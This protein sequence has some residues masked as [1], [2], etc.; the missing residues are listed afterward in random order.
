MSLEFFRSDFLD[1]RSAL[2]PALY[3]TLAFFIVY[4]LV[5]LGPKYGFQSEIFLVDNLGGVCVGIGFV[6]AL[7]LSKKWH[8]DWILTLPSYGTLIATILFLV[9][10]NFYKEVDHLWISPLIIGGI[11]ASFFGTIKTNL[12]IYATYL[13]VPPLIAT[14]FEHLSSYDIIHKQAIIYFLSLVSLYFTHY[15]FKRK[16]KLFKSEQKATQSNLAKSTFLA[17]MSHE[18]RTPMN[19]ILGF[20]KLLLDSKLDAEQ[21]ENV[22]I[23]HSSTQSLLTIIN[24]IL[25]FSKI[26]FGKVDLEQIPFSYEK[27]LYD[28]QSLTNPTAIEK[29]LD[30][31]II[32]PPN[33]P[34]ELIGDSTRVRQI[35]LNLISNS[36]KFTDE[37]SITI[38]VDVEFIDSESLFITTSVI[39]TGIGMTQKQ[40]E[41]IFAEFQQADSSTTRMYGGTGLGTSISK[42]IIQLM[43]GEITVQSQPG[44]GST[45]KFVIPFEASHNEEVQEKPQISFEKN[46]QKTILLAEDNLINQKLALKVFSSLGLETDIANNGKEAIELAFNNDYSIIL[47][48][49]QMPTMDG[50]E[51]IAKLKEANYAKP[52]LAMT[53]NIMPEEV[54]RYQRAGFSDFI[55]K[56]I[57]IEQLVDK[58]DK[59]LSD[60]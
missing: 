46:Y 12:V 45:F 14:Q 3:F 10:E 25:D 53:A 19:G 41:N 29:G 1:R 20:S 44:K 27:I 28:V 17:N 6:L 40:M 31:Q 4:Y 56:P 11:Y 59:Y 54:K 35:L 49:I 52:I 24:D 5:L 50:L 48:D 58:F 47:L 7:L 32:I 2:L 57:E 15:N 51:A 21:K 13:L 30:F 16:L 8:H 37:G 26:E 18:I 43:G 36:I 22:E 9:H 23:I 42:K 34:K 55:S 39:D 38:Q 33:L 60:P